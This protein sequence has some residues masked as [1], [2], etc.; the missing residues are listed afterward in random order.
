MLSFV[1]AI[2]GRDVAA[3]LQGVG[4]DPQAGFLHAD[5]SGRDSLALDVLEEF[6]AWF[7]DRLVLS[8]INRKQIKAAD[9]TVEASGAVRLEAEAR[10][11]ILTAFQERKQE[12]ILHP[13]I[14]EEV[15][16]GLLPHI[17]AQLLA[18]HIRGDL[19]QYP[20]FL[21]R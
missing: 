9:F 17:Q 14:G 1:Y 3:A 21:A 4:L 15:Q 11:T 12:N 6:R 5:R 16:V 7:A 18:R 2:L 19:E 8:L 10:K 13:Y 20:P